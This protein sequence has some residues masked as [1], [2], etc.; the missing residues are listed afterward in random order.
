MPAITIKCLNCGQPFTVRAAGGRRGRR[1][2]CSNAC[3][4]PAFVNSKRDRHQKQ[5]AANLGEPF[6]WDGE[7]VCTVELSG[8]EVSLIN[9]CD[10]NVA[11][12]RVWR[13]HPNGYA[14][15]GT[16]KD[17]AYLHRLLIPIPDGCEIDHINGNRLDN[18]RSNLRAVTHTVNMHN[19]TRPPRSRS[20]VRHVVE[21]H[22]PS[23][24]VYQVKMIPEGRRIY[25]GTFPTLEEAARAAE[26][27]RKI[28]YAPT[29]SGPT[30]QPRC[31]L[32]DPWFE[33]PA[34]ALVV[35][36]CCGVPTC[37]ED[38]EYV[39]RPGRGFTFCYW[40]SATEREE[41]ERE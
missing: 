17:T 8:G 13:L 24:T 39:G 16:R 36:D 27:A 3:K 28:Y 23:G 14:C 20:G 5:A 38:T 41:A 7:L 12:S 9:A 30:C 25:L 35:P 31:P 15:G 34:A 21:V 29:P 1:K 18:R 19:L 40:C 22:H 26:E 2:Y 6:V 4:V 10:A 33:E 11:L 32:T 37:R